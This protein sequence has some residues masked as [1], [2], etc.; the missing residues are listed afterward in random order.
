MLWSLYVRLLQGIGSLIILAVK[1]P[2]IW[3]SIL[4]RAVISLFKAGISGEIFAGLN[5]NLM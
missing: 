5:H 3:F 2:V 4:V 1:C